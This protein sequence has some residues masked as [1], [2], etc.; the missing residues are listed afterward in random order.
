AGLQ[1]SLLR[2]AQVIKT[3]VVSLKE[4]LLAAVGRGDGPAPIADVPKQM[5]RLLARGVDTL[6]VVG[7]RDVGMMY[8]EIF[9]RE[10]LRALE[11]IRGFRRVDFTGTDHLY[12]SLAAQDLLLDTLTGERG[13]QVIG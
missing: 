8:V 4:K 10:E 13:V 12:T 11:R 1:G 2:I 5:R 9:F 3:A 6:L 7:Q